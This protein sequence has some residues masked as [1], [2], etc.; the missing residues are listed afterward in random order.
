MLWKIRLAMLQ[1]E[2]PVA[3]FNLISLEAPALPVGGFWTHPHREERVKLLPGIT[4]KLAA[5]ERDAVGLMK[6]IGEERYARDRPAGARLVSIHLNNKMR[7]H[8]YA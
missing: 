2:Q 6:A 7:P 3:G 1:V 4:G 8:Y 5:C